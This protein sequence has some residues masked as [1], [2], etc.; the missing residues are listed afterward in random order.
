MLI[1]QVNKDIVSGLKYI[2]QSFRKG[3]KGEGAIVLF[4]LWVSLGGF[5]QQNIGISLNWKAEFRK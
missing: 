1:L 3:V 2:Q 4:N 5:L